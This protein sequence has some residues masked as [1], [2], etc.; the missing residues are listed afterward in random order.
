MKE[1][2]LC[3]RNVSKDYLRRGVGNVRVLHDISLEI[4][5][6][7]FFCI[8]G[9][10]GVGKTTLLN[11]IAGLES[12]T[13]GSVSIDGKPVLAQNRKIFLKEKRPVSP[14]SFVFQQPALLPWRTVLENVCLPLQLSATEK[15]QA[16][17]RALSA[18]TSVGLKDVAFSF[19][20]T[21]SGGMRSRVAIARAMVQNPRLLLMD[22]PFASLDPI[23]SET[24]DI[25]LMRYAA[26]RGVTGVFVTHSVTEACLLAH[27]I[28]VMDGGRFVAEIPVSLPWPRSRETLA[29]QEFLEVVKQVR[30]C[31]M[32]TSMAEMMPRPRYVKEKNAFVDVFEPSEDEV[33]VD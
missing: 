33:S 11:I 15:G 19:P 9:P 16:N 31:L 17:E 32:G 27:K 30:T 4:P 24:F 3:V 26:N 13:E 22:E 23:M 2:V 7:E 28:L 20:H 5:E 1:S 29:E 6:G 25:N 18:L 8:L 10:S 12:P 21:L 14:V